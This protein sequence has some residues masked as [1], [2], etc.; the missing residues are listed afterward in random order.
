METAIAPSISKSLR[1]YTSFVVSRLQAV[2][3]YFV[4][5]SM[6]QMVVADVLVDSHV[7]RDEDEYLEYTKL[8]DGFY[9]VLRN[10]KGAGT[11]KTLMDHQQALRFKTV[12]KVVLMKPEDTA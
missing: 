9:A 5:N 3:Q 11:M 8:D 12:E 7:T 1:A 4:T 10:V 6:S 2:A